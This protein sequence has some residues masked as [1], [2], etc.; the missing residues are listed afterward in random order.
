M[1]NRSPTSIFKRLDAVL[2]RNKTAA[3]CM[4]DQAF[5]ISNNGSAE[6]SDEQPVPV[7]SAAPSKAS[8]AELRSEVQRLQRKLQALARGAHRNESISRRFYSL[9]LTLLNAESLPE[10]MDC[11]IRQGRDILGLDQ[12]TLVLRDPEGEVRSL[13]TVGGR[14]ASPPPEIRLIDHLDGWNPTYGTLKTP[15]L[16]PHLDHHTEL[17][18]NTPRLASVAILPL[19]A[20]GYLF[21]SLNFGSIDSARYTRDHAF[22]FHSRLARMVSL[23]LQ[24]AI[25]RERLFVTG[26]TDLLTGWNNRRYLKS[27]LPE[28]LARAVRYAEPLCC[29]L[30]DVDHFKQINDCYGHHVGDD[31]LREL[32][33]RIKQELR[34]SDLTVRYGGEEFAVILI[35]TTRVEAESVAERIRCSIAS[36]ALFV[37]EEGRKL[38]ITVSGGIAELAST[39]PTE[40]TR[41]LGDVMLRR[42]DTAL[43]R[44]KAAGRNCVV[45]HA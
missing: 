39:D 41:I 17:F 13:L 8:P 5:V 16:G 22:D 42:A 11:I 45:C 38:H 1:S 14:F 27:R 25:N 34:T 23:C 12:V 28:E 20:Q 36:D 44:A 15:W 29:L 37:T 40:D 9:E 26:N 3:D 19:I 7:G 4:S 24:N 21:G 35:R 30:L 18:G 2:K 33:G 31:V 32:A 43:Y 10:L 6:P